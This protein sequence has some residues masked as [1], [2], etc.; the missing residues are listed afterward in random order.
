MILFFDTETTGK[1]DFK[2]RGKPEAQ[3][4]IVQLAAILTDDSGKEKACLNVIIKPDGWS[5]PKEA[6]D[7]M[8]SAL[9]LFNNL[10]LQ[11]GTLIAHNIDFDHLVTSCEY[12]R[13]GK[14]FPSHALL[15]CTMHAT[16]PVCKLPGNY[17]DFKWPKLEESYRHLLGK[18]LDGAH[19]A[20]AD[21][22]GC[23]AVYFAFKALPA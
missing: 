13:L 21:V 1:A 11:A 22:R 3:P 15:F 16:T 8:F 9:S 7:P 12:L 2:R 17:G 6:A 10:A 14:E 5:V 19:D 20:L 18:E 4:R 23:A